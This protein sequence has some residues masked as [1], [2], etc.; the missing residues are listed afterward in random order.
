MYMMF[1]QAFGVNSMFVAERACASVKDCTSLRIYM[2]CGTYD[3]VVFNVICR[4]FGALA[5][6]W[7]LKKCCP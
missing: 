6:K 5:S 4:P 1:Y 2:V 3:F 7:L